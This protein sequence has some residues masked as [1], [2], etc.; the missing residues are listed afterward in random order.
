MPLPLAIPIALGVAGAAASIYGASKSGGT[1]RTPMP[2][3]ENYK[4]GGSNEARE[5]WR[6]GLA[7]RDAAALGQAD[8]W[9]AQGAQAREQQA[10]LMGEYQDVAAGKG[11]S[12]AQMQLRQGQQEAAGRAAQMAANTRGGGGN[13]LTAQRMAQSQGA[14]QAAAVNAQAAQLRAGEIERARDAQVGL[15]SGMR[16]G[17][18]SAQS[19]YE[20]RAAGALGARMDLEQTDL[21]AR[22]GYDAAQR[23]ELNRT[24]DLQ[25]QQAQK[26]KD[27]WMQFGGSLIGAAGSTAGKVG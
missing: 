2:N 27:R 8:Q 13:I 25:V 12:I 16:T 7:E 1:V 15:A 19:L 26:N 18:M 5:A 20:Q 4:F 14:E 24:N 23:G 9:G 6:N 10:R 11:P 21:N 22:M 17:D 3:N